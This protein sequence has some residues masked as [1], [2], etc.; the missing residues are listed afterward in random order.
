MSAVSFYKIHIDTY[1]VRIDKHI[2][3]VYELQ[4]F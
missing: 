2:Q 4:I 3:I 1:N